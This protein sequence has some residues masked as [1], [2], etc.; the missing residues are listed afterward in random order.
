MQV[1]FSDDLEPGEGEHKIMDLVRHRQAGGQ[2]DG[3]GKL[4]MAFSQATALVC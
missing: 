4:H 1:I 3:V 2:G